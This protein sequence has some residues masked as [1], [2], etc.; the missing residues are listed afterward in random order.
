MADNFK[1]DLDALYKGKRLDELMEATKLLQ[2]KNILPQSGDISRPVAQEDVNRV[3]AQVYDY[4]ERKLALAASLNLEAKIIIGE[5]HYAKLTPEKGETKY[6]ADSD[7]VIVAVCAFDAARRQG[8]KNFLI[9]QPEDG[10]EKLAEISAESLVE[11]PRSDVDSLKSTT[12]EK[13]LSHDEHS[14]DSDII[15]FLQ[16]YRYAVGYNVKLLAGDPYQNALSNKV[17]EKMLDLSP[18]EMG[19]LILMDEDERDEYINEKYLTLT[20]KHSKK[21]E[22]GIVEELEKTDGHAIGIYGAHHVKSIVKF[23][24]RKNCLIPI[25]LSSSTIVHPDMD[26]DIKMTVYLE[27]LAANKVAKRFIVDG[28]SENTNENVL[29]MVEIA[30]GNYSTPK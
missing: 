17:E 15:S 25:I 26:R 28:I 20:D 29:K 21:R 5:H 2:E 13:I 16:Y 27:K 24:S 9:E 18:K 30:S 6:V 19:K 12:L 10:I 23:F 14:I 7:N 22:E 11:A 1:Y 8:V 4:I 3:Y